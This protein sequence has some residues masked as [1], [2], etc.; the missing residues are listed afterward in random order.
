ML[1]FLHLLLMFFPTIYISKDHVHYIRH[2]LL[3]QQQQIFLFLS[4]LQYNL[5]QAKI[6]YSFLSYERFL[7]TQCHLCNYKQFHQ[8][9]TA[10]LFFEVM[11]FH[12]VTLSVHPTL[13]NIIAFFLHILP[14]TLLFL[15][16][17]QLNFS[18]VYETIKDLY[19]NLYSP[20][21]S[22]IDFL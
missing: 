9:Q 12:P 19:I 15:V 3:H 11:D 16:L 18:N 21:L 22:D 1:K 4:L 7:Q 8:D 20:P 5:N 10:H 6:S 14:Q 17:W 2:S 13:S